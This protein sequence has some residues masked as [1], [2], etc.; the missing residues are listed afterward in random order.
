ML[1][2]IVEV[3]DVTIANVALPHMQASFSASVDEITWVLT[4]YLVSNGIVIPITGWLSARLGRKRFFVGS[5]LLFTVSSML[6]GTAWSL[7]SMV[8][9]RVV[10]GAAG[11]AMIP[12]SQAVLMEAFPPERQG[13]AM[14]VWG[15][16]L[17]TAPVLGPTLGG[18]ITDNYHWR[19][20]FFVNLPVGLI[21]ALLQVA[22]VPEPANQ[23][24]SAGKIDWVG[25]LLVVIAIGAL[26]IVLD[27]G[28]RA[29]WFASP[30]VGWF[31]LVSAAAFAILIA[32]ELRHEDPVVDLALFGRRVFAIASSLTVLLSFSL[33][34]NVI[35]WPLYLQHV[36]GYPA[37]QAGLA[38]APRGLATMASMFL[39]G[40]A[41]GRIDTRLLLG[42][43]FVLVGIGSLEMSR[44]TTQWGFWEMVWPSLIHGFG[45]G[46]T[47]VPLSA[48][49][50]AAVPPN[51]VDNASGL[52]NLMRNTGGSV[53]IA[54]A[55]TLIVRRSQW[56]QAHLVEHLHATN[57]LY[58]QALEA[59]GRVAA[60]SG[61]DPYTASQR[62]TGLLYGLVQREA[63]DLAF[64]DVFLVLA[65]VS[66]AMLPFLVLVGRVRGKLPAAH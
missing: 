66:F 55:G 62:A 43:G 56:H 7:E 40:L 36:V 60:A 49:A 18:W 34:G 24:S 65:V 6:C 28:E 2:T 10:Q 17:M 20:I 54:I 13:L 48:A 27:R 23:R 4:S 59:A 29:D 38:M 64:D 22:F 14:A 3:L 57:P 37:W 9:F 33:Y 8:T 35:T 32:Y 53:G 12:L 1:A 63:A 52:Y 50:L 61:A 58:S 5:T 45:M 25:L 47:F 42:V 31:C 51:R 44:F 16:G 46:F 19:W 39:V 15:I 41:Y 11:A 26:Q 21:A 30:W